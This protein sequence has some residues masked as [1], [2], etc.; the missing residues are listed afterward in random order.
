MDRELNKNAYLNQLFEQKGLRGPLVEDR[1]EPK[2][3]IK[4]KKEVAARNIAFER[5]I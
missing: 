2:D 3:F 1:S 5:E 4:E